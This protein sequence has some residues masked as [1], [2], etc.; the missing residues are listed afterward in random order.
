MRCSRLMNA[1]T[2]LLLALGMIA[3]AAQD[4]VTMKGDV[5]HLVEEALQY[6]AAHLAPLEPK[7]LAIFRL[8]MEL[9]DG[10]NRIYTL[11]TR[12]AKVYLPEEL[13]R[14]LE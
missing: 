5:N 3:W 1:R 4:V 12:I 10:L 7:R 9:M 6:Q 14:K 8:E 2:P 13:I 11:T